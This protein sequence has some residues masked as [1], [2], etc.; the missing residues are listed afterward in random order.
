MKFNLGEWDAVVREMSVNRQTEI[1]ELDTGTH[2][3][4]KIEG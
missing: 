2:V 1:I 4:M 3:L